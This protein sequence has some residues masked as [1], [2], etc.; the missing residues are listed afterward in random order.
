[1]SK[2]SYPQKLRV[3]ATPSKR[4]RL[5]LEKMDQRREEDKQEEWYKMMPEEIPLS[6]WAREQHRQARREL[7]IKKITRRLLGLCERRGEEMGTE[8]GECVSRPSWLIGRFEN[9]VCHFCGRSL[10]VATNQE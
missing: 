10:T 2:Y 5:K 3:A 6:A 4:D 7:A 9:R 1:M 8:E